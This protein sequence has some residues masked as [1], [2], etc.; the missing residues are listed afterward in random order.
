MTAD[1]SANRLAAAPPASGL[2]PRIR[3]AVLAAL[4]GAIALEVASRV[5]S[6]TFG[7][8]TQAI[9]R[10]MSMASTVTVAVAIIA[11]VRLTRQGRRV[12]FFI[13]AAVVMIFLGQLFGITDEIAALEGVPLFGSGTTSNSIARTLADYGGLVA[14]VL[15]FFLMIFDLDDAYRSLDRQRRL[16]EEQ[17]AKRA[18]Q[19]RAIRTSEERYR[20]LVEA[21]RVIPWEVDLATWRFTYVGPH[22]ETLLGYPIAEWYAENFWADHIHGD[23]RAFAVQYCLAQ[24][25]KGL[26]HDFEYRMIRADGS[27]VW[28]RDIVSVVRPEN[29]PAMLRGV[30]IDITDQRAGAEA[31]AASE[32]RFRFLYDTTPVMMHSIDE[33]SRIIDVN[34]YWLDVMGYRR[35]EVLGR[36]STEFLTDES[37]RLA[38]EVYLPMYWRDGIIDS[39]EY[40]LVRKNGEIFDALLSAVVAAGP[41]GDGKS[42]LAFIIDVSERKRIEREQ[43]EL[44][45]QMEHAQKLESLGVLAGGIAHDFNNILMS[46]VGNASLALDEDAPDG[47]TAPFLREIERDARRGAELCRQMLAYSGKGAFAVASV[48]LNAVVRDLG[49]L[50]EASHTK[51]IDLTYDLSDAT[52]AIEADVGQLNQVVMNLIINA[53]EAIGDEAGMVTV[54]TEAADLDASD[55]TAYY[56]AEA[57]RPGRYA[58]LTVRDTGSG[59]SD[60]VI[61]RIFEPFFSTKFTGRGLGMAVVLGIVRGHGGAIRVVSA[62]N[63]GTAVRIVLPAAERSAAALPAAGPARGRSGAI[64]VAD[65]EPSVL[66]VTRRILEKAGYAVV[67]VQNGLQAVDA[68]R[69]DHAGIAAVVLDMTMPVMSGAEAA[70]AIRTIDPSVPIVLTS[71]YAAQDI[72]TRTHDGGVTGYLQKPYRPQ[73]LIA[74]MERLAPAP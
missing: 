16:L 72:R 62:P 32:A 8:E 74:L 2:T 6:V 4:G 34:Q 56:G 20:N 3:T 67:A 45:E 25:E 40:R 53:S 55:L 61:G 52:P 43:R 37:R 73:E 29:G 28:L 51:K 66:D 64:L 57:L 23:D 26:S 63:Q 50:L 58:A 70:E 60:E 11:L 1:E 39:V 44:R 65:D 71:G 38:E 54:S 27:A 33:E 10:A 49:E 17:L 41:N 7:P 12:R 48:D 46:I 31:L 19:E 68:F 15:G 59:M 36:R 47:R 21:A 35:E 42:S 18:E 22:A 30:M 24:T 13:I 5:L 69:A 14:L 9:E